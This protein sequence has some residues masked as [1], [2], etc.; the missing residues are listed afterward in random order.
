M[1]TITS[2]FCLKITPLFLV[3]TYLK[4]L[5]L[6][7]YYIN[8][9]GVQPSRTP[10]NASSTVAKQYYISV[11]PKYANKSMHFYLIR[12]KNSI[13]LETQNYT[14]ITRYLIVILFGSFILSLLKGFCQSSIF[15]KKNTRLKNQVQ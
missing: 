5:F 12:D 10:K 1:V 11:F 4:K 7:F 3:T 2:M 9:K 13:R 15:L 8:K 14:K 6:F